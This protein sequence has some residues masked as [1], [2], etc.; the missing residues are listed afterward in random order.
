MKICSKCKVEKELT[1][2]SKQKRGKYGVKSDCKDCEKLYRTANKERISEYMK[3]WH[4]DN[5]QN[6]K[7]QNAEYKKQWYQSNK[8]Q[9]AKQGKLYRQDNKKQRKVYLEDNKERLAEKA[10]LYYQ[11]PLGK[12]ARKASSHNRR[13]LVRSSQGKHTAKDILVLFD[14]QSGKCPYCKTNLSKSG[15]NKYHVD[16]ILPLSKGGTNDIG[17]IQLLCPKCNLTKNDKLPE[18]FAQEIGVLL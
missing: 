3:K 18:E 9:V 15:K 16:H 10:K 7:E 12:A 2:F 11:T 17:N 13:A 5:Y 4:Q 14:L 6:N 1:E 8:D